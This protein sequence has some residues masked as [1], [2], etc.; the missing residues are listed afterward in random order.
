MN[1][2]SDLLPYKETKEQDSVGFVAAI[3]HAYFCGGDICVYHHAL[4]ID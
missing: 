2:Y 4:N 3:A 1:V